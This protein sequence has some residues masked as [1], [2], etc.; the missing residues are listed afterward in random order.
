MFVNWLDLHVNIGSHGALCLSE[1]NQYSLTNLGRE[2]EHSVP[3]L[4]S[5]QSLIEQLAKLCGHVEIPLYQESTLHPAAPLD[6][7]FSQFLE[8]QTL[9]IAYSLSI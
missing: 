5:F 2:L 1:I 8:Y 6:E 4:K 3:G 7:Q 9:I